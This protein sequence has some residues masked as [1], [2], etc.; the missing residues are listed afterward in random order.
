MAA[1]SKKRVFITGIDSF[2]AVHLEKE[3]ILNG[4]EVYGSTFSEPNEE[5]HFKCNILEKKELRSVFKKIVPD[6]I[7]HLAAISFVASEN[8]SLMYQTNIQGTL[9]FLEVLEELEIMPAKILIAS[10]AAVY[11]NIGS[12]LS[13][14][15]SPKPINHYGNSKLAMENMVSNYFAKFNIIIT[16]PFNYTGVGQRLDFLVPKIICHF[17]EKK[18][19]IELGNLDTYREYNDVRFMTSTYISLLETNHKSDIVNISSGITYS[20]GDI[21]K[22]LSELSNHLI[23]VKVNKK[24]VRKNEIKELKGSTSKLEKLINKKTT[25]YLLEDTLKEMYYN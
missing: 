3:L 9:N 15:M 20:I 1:P 2:T 17:K 6:Y 11:G 23:E 22:I 4:Y 18:P 7:I 13:E 21:L 14:E 24:F 5:N 16:R 19:V 8:I 12:Q 10:S 25:I